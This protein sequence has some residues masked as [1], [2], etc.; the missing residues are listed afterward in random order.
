MLEH[1]QPLAARAQAVAP[2]QPLH[3]ARRYRQPPPAG[4]IGRQAPTAPGGLRDRDREDLPLGLGRELRQG[5]RPRAVPPRMQAV[6][7]I[8]RQPRLPAIEQGPRDPRFLTRRADT[9]LARATDHLQPHSLYALVEGHSSVLPK[10]FPL[11]CPSKVQTLT[12]VRT[13]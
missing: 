4:D 13:P 6:D 10:W 9:D 2:Q 3:R 5:P 7:A 1:Q 8:A 12:R 11:S